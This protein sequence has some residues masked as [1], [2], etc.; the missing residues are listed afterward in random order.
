M[1]RRDFDFVFKLWHF[2]QFFIRFPKKKFQWKLILFVQINTS[3]GIE[4]TCKT[5]AICMTHFHIVSFQLAL[6]SDSKFFVRLSDKCHWR[7]LRVYKHT[8]L[9]YC[10]TSIACNPLLTLTVFY[11]NTHSRTQSHCMNFA[12]SSEW[13][14]AWNELNIVH[15]CRWLC[16]FYANAW[17]VQGTF[18]DCVWQSIVISAIYTCFCCFFFFFFVNRTSGLV[19]CSFVRSFAWL[20]C[21]SLAICYPEA[22]VHFKYHH[23]NVTKTNIIPWPLLYPSRVYNAHTLTQRGQLNCCS[24]VFYLLYMF[25]SKWYGLCF[26]HSLRKLL[27][28]CKKPHPWRAQCMEPLCVCVVMAATLVWEWFNE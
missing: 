23:L 1:I 24:I 22:M 12:K 3:I 18:T 26:C 14:G 7:A 13:E 27:A 5:K 15:D 6:H 16:S 25:W 19:R 4:L 28:H 9:L 20:F 10:C 8:H 11:T 21:Y 2:L 17:R